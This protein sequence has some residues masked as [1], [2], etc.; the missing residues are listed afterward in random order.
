MYYF[1]EAQTMEDGT[2]AQAIYAKATY[3]DA[4]AAFHASLAYAAQVETVKRCLCVVMN[5]KGLIYKNE[6]W[7][8]NPEEE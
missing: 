3:A 4:V 8:R 2:T 1:I 6:V 7:E 5:D